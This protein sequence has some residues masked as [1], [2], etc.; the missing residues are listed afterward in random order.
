ML[1]ETR[2]SITVARSGRV[3]VSKNVHT[4]VSSPFDRV[5]CGIDGSEEGLEAARQAARLAR[6]S[7]TLVA[8]VDPWDL[9]MAGSADRLRAEA[10]A[11]L[12]A[13][14]SAAEPRCAIDS[15]LIE[16]RP[17]DALLREA[18]R[19]QATLIA[20]GTHGRG[21]L[22]G[23]A[24]G[25]VATAI[26]HRACCSVLLA[27]P[28][29]RG[30]E[31]PGTVVVGVDGSPESALASSAAR[32]LRERF[33]ATTRFVLGSRGGDLDAAQAIAAP[34]EI[35]AI[36]EGPVPAL[37]GA[38]RDAD[39]LV[40]GSRGLRGL[41]ALGSVSERVVHAAPC[42]VLVVRARVPLPSDQ[43]REPTLVRDLMSTPVVVAAEE[44]RLDEIARMMLEHE[45][46]AVPIVSDDRKLV[47]IISESDFAGRE[48][49]FATSRYGHQIRL[50]KVLGELMF[51]GDAL[52]GIYEASQRLR[53]RSVMSA[54]VHVASEDEPVQQA[55][56]RMLHHEIDHMPVVRGGVPVGMLARYDL[57]RLAFRT[58][59]DR[60][61][62]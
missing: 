42:S 47:G 62:D 61:G 7:L 28:R 49:V 22:V 4:K 46:G 37:L 51:V 30:G 15:K 11:A 1:D 20:V 24:L 18:S 16:A 25:S 29:Q 58:W 60:S 36:P 39:V 31:F 48:I 52:E 44:T 45:I 21:R 10:A 43:P 8:A 17:A 12:E 57:L 33:G 13:A 53:A 35:V 3:S 23:I 50:P 54:P 41:R 27:R 38:A 56:T 55:L 26:A 34:D 6:E 2:C 5:V 40:V 59:E 19:S 32:E 9:Q 14:R